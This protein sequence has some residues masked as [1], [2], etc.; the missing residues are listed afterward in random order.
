MKCTPCKTYRATLRTLYNR[1]S[2]RSS[3]SISDASSHANIRYMNTPEK[4]DKIMKLK[5]KA[6]STEKEV[7]K[8]QAKIKKLTQEQG[9]S[10]D[11]ALHGDL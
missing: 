7:S 6:Q 5:K 11:E 2:R 1:Y 10:V 3:D 9:E 8:L 4:K